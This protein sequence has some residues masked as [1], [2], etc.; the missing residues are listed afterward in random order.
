MG[1]HPHDF[2]NTYDEGE[3][4]FGLDR[5]TDEKSLV[6]YLQKFTDDALMHFLAKRYL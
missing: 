4:A 6:A 5:E 1:K 2:V 3:I